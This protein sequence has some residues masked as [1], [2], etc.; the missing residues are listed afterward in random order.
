MIVAYFLHSKDTRVHKIDHTKWLAMQYP[1]AKY[2]NTNHK[3]TKP[4]V[5]GMSWGKEPTPKSTQAW[6]IPKVDEPGPGS[7]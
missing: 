6:V 1:P 3:I 5:L 2:D 4:R 7:Y